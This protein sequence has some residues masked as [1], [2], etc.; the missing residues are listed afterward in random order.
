MDNQRPNSTEE[1]SPSKLGR[2]EFLTASAGAI[3]APLLAQVQTV[4]WQKQ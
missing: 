3:A 2:R 4:F 1:H